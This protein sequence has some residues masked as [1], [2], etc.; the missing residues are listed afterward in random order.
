[1]FSG[2]AVFSG[3]GL[4]VVSVQNDLKELGVSD[5]SKWII[6]SEKSHRLDLLIPAFFSFASP[7]FC[8]SINAVLFAKFPYAPS[9]IHFPNP[10]AFVFTPSFRRYRI[11]AGAGV[12]S[13][14]IWAGQYS[15]QDSSR[16]KN[17]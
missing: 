13:G 17:L 4:Q 14:V 5:Q 12:E 15:A 8:R 10:S 3:D 1:M 16:H 11:C 9:S 6:I 7:D 2:D